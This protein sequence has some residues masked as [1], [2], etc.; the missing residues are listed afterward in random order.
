MKEYDFFVKENHG[1]FWNAFPVEVE[2]RQKGLRDENAELVNELRGEGYEASK[3]HEKKLCKTRHEL[4]EA[5]TLK[6]Q[7]QHFDKE[8]KVV[9][10]AIA[11]GGAESAMKQ[12]GLK[13]LAGQFKEHFQ[14][15]G[16]S[17]EASL[18]QRSSQEQS[19]SSNVTD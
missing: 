17:P 6:N 5:V 7:K 14:W 19:S 13:I 3:D 1:A 10:Q 15:A 9:L 8:V 18:E 16:F 11:D 2:G 12:Q 4:V